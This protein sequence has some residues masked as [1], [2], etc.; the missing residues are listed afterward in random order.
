MPVH[1]CERRRRAAPVHPWVGSAPG[2]GQAWGYWRKAQRRLRALQDVSMAQ[3][4]ASDRETIDLGHSYNAS[5]I[6]FQGIRPADR[7]S[8]FDWARPFAAPSTLA[9]AADA[10]APHTCLAA[11]RRS[12]PNAQA[13]SLS[14][15][16]R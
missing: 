16:A 5:S 11:H 4:I 12:R 1:A 10:A 13:A 9:N 7:R 2:G 15:S 14:Q 3:A 8:I 6:V